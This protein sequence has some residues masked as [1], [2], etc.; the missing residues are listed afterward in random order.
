MRIS[1][2]GDHAGFEL[3]ERV[4]T[5]LEQRRYQVTDMGTCGG[6]SV[7]YPD[8]AAA[9]AQ[10]VSSGQADRGVLVCGTGIGMS[11]AANKFANVRAALCHDVE[12]ARLS[13]QHNNAN[14]LA[15]GSRILDPE[16]ALAVVQE[17]LDTTFEGGRHSL[18]LQKITDLEGNA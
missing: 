13:R 15:I 1:I 7:D 6:E 4:K 3:K 11:I 8:Y 18:R 5:L 17:W 12:T 10:A 16:L 2:G 9:V 14:V